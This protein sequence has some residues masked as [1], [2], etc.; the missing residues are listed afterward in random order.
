MKRYLKVAFIY[1]L[2]FFSIGIVNAKTTENGVKIEG[3][4]NLGVT[5]S[6]VY[7]D[8]IY[9]IIDKNTSDEVF[10]VEPDLIFL[11]FEDTTLSSASKYNF[12][13]ENGNWDCPKYAIVDNQNIT[14]FKNDK[15]S[16]NNFLELDKSESYCEGECVK[17]SNNSSANE[18]EC[19]YNGLNII[20]TG[21]KC[22]VT[23]PDGLTENIT[24]GI[25]GS[26]IGSNKCPDIYFNSKTKEL[27]AATYDYN[28]W[29]DKNVN[30]YDPDLYDF[31]C[32]SDRKN[33]EYLCV[34]KCEYENNKNIR[35]NKISNRINGKT[36]ISLLGFCT[37]SKVARLLK[38]VG[39]LIVI[40]KILVP[41]IIILMGFVNLF[42]IITAGKEDEARKYAKSIVTKIIIGVIIFLLPGLINFVFD[43]ANNIIASS[44]EYQ[45]EFTNCEKCILDIGEC[46][47]NGN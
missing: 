1:I 16:T 12:L 35:C 11:P 36:D 30:N 21:N 19:N 41:A 39:I 37:E 15:P 17:S 29:F 6:C 32:G 5:L 2:L 43:I 4:D 34:D 28:A 44:S 46:N 9:V 7:S 31:L 25:C 27:K 18:Y 33:V 14:D 47:T 42:K 13:N 45:S 10:E 26:F 8:D 20:G 24:N 40:A 23:Y 22:S 3:E 38:G